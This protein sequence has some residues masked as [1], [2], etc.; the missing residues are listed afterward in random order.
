MCYSSRVPFL[1][2]LIFKKLFLCINCCCDSDQYIALNCKLT[3]YSSSGCSHVGNIRQLHPRNYWSHW[4]STK[5]WRHSEERAWKEVFIFK[6]KH[7]PFGWLIYCYSQINSI[8]YF[9]EG[10]FNNKKRLHKYNLVECTLVLILDIG[11]S[12]LDF[13]LIF[14]FCWIL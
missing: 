5:V 1:I 12:L 11:K 8:S 4:N 9:K 7:R 14:F 6:N 13:F 10:D 2:K 3:I